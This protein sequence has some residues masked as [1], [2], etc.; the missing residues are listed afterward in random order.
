MI[1]FMK[2]LFT[3][4]LSLLFFQ[5][6]G[7]NLQADSIQ[8]LLNTASTDTQKVSALNKIAQ[9]LIK[10][11]PDSAFAIADKALKLAEKN[12]FKKGAGN[13]LLIIGK[14]YKEKEMIP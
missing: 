4:I 5:L 14:T 7:T 12:K 6:F 9:Q 11:D 13:S 2:T 1:G 3:F 8:K 10:N